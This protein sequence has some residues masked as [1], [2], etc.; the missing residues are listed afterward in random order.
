MSREGSDK[1]N[2]RVV[3]E[4]SLVSGPKRSKSFTTALA[5]L[6]VV[7][8]SEES[9]QEISTVESIAEMA[10][11]G[12]QN[13]ELNVEGVYLEIES[14]VISSKHYTARDKQEILAQKKIWLAVPGLMNARDAEQRPDEVMVRA[15][16]AAKRQMVLYAMVGKYGWDVALRTLKDRDGAALGLPEP[17]INPITYVKAEKTYASK[18]GSTSYGASQT[19]A[20]QEYGSGRGQ[21][22]SRGRGRSSGGGRRY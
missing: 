15:G 12:D 17:V 2:K 8:D 5:S 11:F 1:E 9:T 7:E 13:H 4:N 10:L 20:K 14:M 21:S 16:I 22:F 18:Y 6:N 19:Y 3:E